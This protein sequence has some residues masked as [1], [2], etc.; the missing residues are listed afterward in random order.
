MTSTIEG[1]AK[2]R[3]GRGTVRGFRT[4]VAA[5]GVMMLNG[6][7]LT[8]PYWNQEFEDHTDAIPMQAFTFDASEQVRF[9]CAKAYHGGLYPSATTATWVLVG[10]ATPQS[11]PLLDSY[12]AGVHGARRLST[13]PATCWRF[14]PA[15]S[16]WYA[17]V[18][19][20]QNELVADGQNYFYTF[21]KAGLECL[22]REV[23]KAASWTGWIGKSCT[24]SQYYTI[25]RAVS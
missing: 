14:D 13:L 20:T 17:A 5:T 12:S 25:F 18:R 24:A 11:Q 1:V 19:A 22:G 8:S 9:E 10:N 3:I 2:S 7:L 21:T 15:N 16:I 6:C 4:L 23:G